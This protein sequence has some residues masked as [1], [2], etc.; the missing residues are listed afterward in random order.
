[1]IDNNTARNF[2]AF[3]NR[4]FTQEELDRIIKQLRETEKALQDCLDKH[5]GGGKFKI[6]PRLAFPPEEQAKF[7]NCLGAC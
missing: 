5:R 3:G 6:N 4:T 2:D 1:M 7:P